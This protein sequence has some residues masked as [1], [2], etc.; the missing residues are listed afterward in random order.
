MA[1]YPVRPLPCALK[2]PFQKWVGDVMP[3]RPPKIVIWCNAQSWY[4]SGPYG[5]LMTVGAYLWGIVFTLLW[6]IAMMATIVCVVVGTAF[7]ALIIFFALCSL[8][9]WMFRKLKGG[10]TAPAASGRAQQFVPRRGGQ[11][12]GVKE[13]VEL[14]EVNR[15]GN[16][17]PVGG[18]EA[19]RPVKLHTKAPRVPS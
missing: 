3:Y 10:E 1:I 7:L 14:G 17:G 19:Q 15:N 8:V 18:T 16:E 4:K 9:S 5:C 6:F 2:D 13:D 11:R 12:A